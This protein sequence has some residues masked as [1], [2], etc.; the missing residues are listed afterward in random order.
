MQLPPLFLPYLECVHKNVKKTNFRT[1]LLPF[2]L[3]LPISPFFSDLLSRILRSVIFSQSFRI[4][5]YRCVRINCRV[6]HLY[7][8]SSFPN[9]RVPSRKLSSRDE[10]LSSMVPALFNLGSSR[11]CG[12]A[13]YYWIGIL[14]CKIYDSI[15][16]IV[17]H[18]Y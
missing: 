5:R 7:L 17:V 2:S 12:C 9:F 15:G 10:S 3:Y 18:Q 6:Y 1:D 4:V 11:R 16:F 13:V 8:S 14:G